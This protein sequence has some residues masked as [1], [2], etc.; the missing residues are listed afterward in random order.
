MFPFDDVIMGQIWRC[1]H[2]RQK[3]NNMMAMGKVHTLDLIIIRRNA[4]IS[5]IIKIRFRQLKTY[6]PEWLMYYDKYN[7]E[8]RLHLMQ[9]WQNIPNQAFTYSIISFIVRVQRIWTILQYNIYTCLFST[10]SYWFVQKY[11]VAAVVKRPFNFITWN[12]M[13]GKTVIKSGTR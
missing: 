1:D 3:M 6:S 11:F 9:S 12:R 7:W 5:L 2:F 4:C 10:Y 13:P 8:L